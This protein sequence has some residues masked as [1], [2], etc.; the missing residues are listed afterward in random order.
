MKIILAREAD[1]V[2]D[3]KVFLI[4]LQTATVMAVVVNLDSRFNKL[5]T[6]SL[7]HPNLIIPIME[8]PAIHHLKIE[9][10]RNLENHK[11]AKGLEML[12]A[13]VCTI[14]W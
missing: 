12:V 7:S 2:E 4:S 8:A 10:L 1:L 11:K 6:A 9:F 5:E 3:N 14:L 13:Q